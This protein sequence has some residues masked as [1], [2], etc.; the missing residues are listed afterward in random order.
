MLQ[1]KEFVRIELLG[2]H[3]GQIVR[4]FLVCSDLFPNKITK[5]IE[6]PQIF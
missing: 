5:K 1:I 4:L 3:W 6:N 2:T